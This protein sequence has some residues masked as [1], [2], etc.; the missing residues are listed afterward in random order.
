M[1]VPRDFFLTTDRLGFSHW[2][3]GDLAMAGT[4]WGDPKVAEFI[5]GP[6]TAEDVRARLTREIETMIARGI[7]YWPVFLFKMT[8]SQA[9]RD[10]GLMGTTSA[11]MSWDF[12]FGRSTGAGA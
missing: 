10:C 2:N 8:I 5:G 1:L 7:Q 12:T 9:V 3:Q 11:F 6:F 4:L